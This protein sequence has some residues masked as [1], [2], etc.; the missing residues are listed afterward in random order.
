MSGCR[1]LRRSRSG[2][3]WGLPGRR[4]ARRA[5]GV[6]SGPWGPGQAGE[7]VPVGVGRIQGTR[8]VL[9]GEGFRSTRAWS[10]NRCTRAWRESEPQREGLV[11]F[12]RGR[13]FWGYRE[14]GRGLGSQIALCEWD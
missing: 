9:A 1:G 12:Q 7:G 5:A 8:Q 6:P 3:M 4:L 14:W 2:E 13:E 10:R 11:T